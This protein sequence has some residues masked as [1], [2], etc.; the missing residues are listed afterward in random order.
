MHS[1]IAQSAGTDIS[2]EVLDVHLHPSGI[3]RRFPNNAAGIRALIG[4]LGGFIIARVVFEPTGAYHRSFERQLARAGFAL[5]K[6]NP[7]QA[8]RFAEA[9]GRPAKTD[10]LDAAML[11]RFGALIEPPARPVVSDILAE[12]KELQVARR[13]LIEDRTAALNRAQAHQ[14]ALLKRQGAARLRHIEGQIRAIDAALRRLLAAEPALK[15]RFDVLLSVPGIAETTALALLIE[16]PELGQLENGCAAS[17]AGL[18]P[19][20]RDSGQWRGKRF[21]RGGRASVRQALYMP[22]L[23]AARFNPDLRAKYQALIAAGKPAKV[24]LVAIMR[25]LIILANALLRE[26]RAWAPRASAPAGAYSQPAAQAAC[27]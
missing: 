14:S 21:I 13:A 9:I 19:L 23:V 6:V 15:A 26:G 11:A 25:K 27:D 3:A 16:M 10:P 7:R 5:A 17:L 18:A 2:K 24:A 1:T 12:M 20:A 22:A 8:R 4:W